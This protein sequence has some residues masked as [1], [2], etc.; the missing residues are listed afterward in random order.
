MFQQVLK[1]FYFEPMHSRCV[2]DTESNE[3]IKHPVYDQTQLNLYRL[4]KRSVFFYHKL[5]VSALT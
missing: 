4:L 2:S 1:Y 3:Y 5:H